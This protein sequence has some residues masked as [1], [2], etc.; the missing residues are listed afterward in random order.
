[1][2]R[3]QLCHH[4]RIC[5]QHQEGLPENEGTNTP[6]GVEVDETTAK[7]RLDFDRRR[8]KWLWI[9]A[10]LYFLIFLN[11]L[12]LGIA[13]AGKLPLVAIIFAE[14]LNG[15]ILTV[16]ILEIRKVH[17]RLESSKP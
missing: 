14:F 8:L 13:Y 2:R 15:S 7:L 10:G 4:R 3:S 12:R 5:V 16:F 1:V 6:K 9:G 17:D 11:G